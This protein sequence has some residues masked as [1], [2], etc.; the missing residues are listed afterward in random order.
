MKQFVK[1][2]P[3]NGDCFKYLYK[4][5]PHLS[6]AKLNEGIF[7]GTDTCKLMFDSNFEATSTKEKKVWI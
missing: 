4:K 2:F 6:E 7:V 3:K 5:Y 1:A